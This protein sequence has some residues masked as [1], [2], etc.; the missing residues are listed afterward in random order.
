MSGT[1]PAPCPLDHSR[2][3]GGKTRFLPVRRLGRNTDGGPPLYSVFKRRIWRTGARDGQAPIGKAGA[4]MA[5]ILS[6]DRHAYAC[7]LFVQVSCFKLSC[8]NVEPF[9]MA[10][11]AR[12]SRSGIRPQKYANLLKP[13][14]AGMAELADAADSKSAEVHPSWGFNSPS[15]HHSFTPLIN[16]IR[17]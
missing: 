4:D 13:L 2:S 7:Q 11:T 3:P 12:T 6:R 16:E 8:L 10:G 17:E 14:L 15:R 9:K 1:L 5:A